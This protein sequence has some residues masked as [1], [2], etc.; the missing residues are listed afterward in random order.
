MAA[1][2]EQYWR[3]YGRSKELEDVRGVLGTGRWFF[4]AI[5]GR[6]RIGK[7]TLIQRAVR[8]LDVPHFYFQVPDSDERGV[9]ETFQEALEDYELPTDAA[10]R[11]RTFLDMATAVDRLCRSGVI[12]IIDEF[13]YFHRDRM[14]AFASHLQRC[15]DGLRDT[16][17][18]GLFVLGSVHTEMTAILDD[19]RS[20]LF[21]RI[22]HRIGVGHLDLETLFEMFDAHGVHTPDRQLLLWTL[23]EGVPKFY[24][25]CFEQGVLS[26]DVGRE[27]I[28]RVLF[29]EGPSPLRDEAASWFL[30]EIGGGYESILRLVAKHGPCALG[31]LRAEYGRAGS[32]DDKKLSSYL[33]TLIDR[34]EMIEKLQPVFA[35]TGSRKARYQLRDNFLT[36]WLKAIGRSVSAARVQ[37]VEQPLRKASERLLT[38]E[39]LVFERLVRSGM[40]E[41]SRKGVGDF[42]LTDIVRGYWNK[43]DGSDIEL[44]LIA[45]NE[46]DRVVRIG[47]CKRSSGAHP[48]SLARFNQHIARFLATRTGQRL[49]GWSV[50]RALYAPSFDPDLRSRLGGDGYV[51]RDLVDLRSALG[52]T[53][54]QLPLDFDVNR[55]P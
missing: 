1:T 50:E 33:T 16:T 41:C 54:P 20:P 13:Q 53:E 30:K 52:P 6:R 35:A 9:V 31:R 29:F 23:F 39:G 19:R 15:V 8:Q 44:D 24:R 42:Q 2:T 3:F 37:P 12:V 55:S 5:S 43:A 27:D 45:L 40:E 48:G 28:L 49:N 32:G 21:N 46:D 7:T 11:F 14:K 34:Y 36:A 47:S 26:D 18:G 22:T 51:C 10:R 4:C 17:V 38:H 25:D